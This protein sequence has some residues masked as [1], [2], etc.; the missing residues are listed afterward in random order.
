MGE[1]FTFTFKPPEKKSPP[2][3]EPGFL[4][5]VFNLMLIMLIICGILWTVIDCY[6]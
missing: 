3:A 4:V 5:F 6:S 2:K 1:E